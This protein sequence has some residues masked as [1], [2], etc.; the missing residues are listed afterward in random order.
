MSLSLCTPAEAAVASLSSPS[1][2]YPSVSTCR[3]YSQYVSHVSVGRIL[4]PAGFRT[5]FSEGTQIPRALPHHEEACKAASAG[6]RAECLSCRFGVG[7]G[8]E[9]AREARHR[10]EYVFAHTEVVS[11]LS[12]TSRKG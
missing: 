7:E 4:L 10:N 5:S 11:A 6:C 9:K 2:S 3:L 8:D 1:P 12:F